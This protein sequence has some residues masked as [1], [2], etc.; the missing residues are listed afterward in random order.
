MVYVP[1]KEQAKGALRIF[2]PTAVV[3]AAAKGWIHIEGDTETYTADLIDSLAGAV[4]AAAVLWSVWENSRTGLIK[5][6]ASLPEVQQVVTDKKMAE[7][8]PLKDN[9]K[10]VSK[11]E[12]VDSLRRSGTR[13]SRE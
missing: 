8:G 7:E 12:E 10:V 11:R 2:I 1:T 3:Y 13:G 4:V 5:S 9:V 6:A